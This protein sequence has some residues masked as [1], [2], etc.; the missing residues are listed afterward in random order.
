LETPPSS[1]SPATT[2]TTNSL[3]VSAIPCVVRQYF[4]DN[5]AIKNCTLDQ[6]IFIDN[7]KEKNI[8]ICLFTC[9]L[10]EVDPKHNYSANSY[11]SD[12]SFAISE[13]FISVSYEAKKLPFHRW[14]HLCFVLVNG[15]SMKLYIDGQKEKNSTYNVFK[16][17]LNTTY[18]IIKY[19]GSSDNLIYMACSIRVIFSEILEDPFTSLPAAQACGY[20]DLDCQTDRA[21]I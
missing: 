13:R 6:N 12:I 9:T 20:L 21:E 1:P 10:Q 8:F 4:Y 2:T 5:F 19:E 18:Y 16:G 15:K 11:P 14:T 7:F 3:G 17:N